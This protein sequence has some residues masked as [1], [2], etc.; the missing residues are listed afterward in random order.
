MNGKAFPSLAVH[1]L[2]IFMWLFIRKMKK[3]FEMQIKNSILS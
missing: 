1:Y 2:F 3:F